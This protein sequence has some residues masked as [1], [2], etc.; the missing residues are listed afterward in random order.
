MSAAFFF[1][2]FAEIPDE[3]SEG[4]ELGSELSA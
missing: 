4:P 1:A 2:A 3:R